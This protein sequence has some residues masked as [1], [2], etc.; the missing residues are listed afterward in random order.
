MSIASLR[1]EIRDANL[2]YLD[3]RPIDE[4]HR[5]DGVMDVLSDCEIAL[6]RFNTNRNN[7]NKPSL[8]ECYGFLQILYVQQDAVKELSQ[9]YGLTG[10]GVPNS[11]TPSKRSLRCARV[12]NLRNQLA[13][14]P[15]RNWARTT[16]IIPEGLI[17]NDY[18]EYALYG[19]GAVG[20]SSFQKGEVNF[21]EFIAR[22]E[23]SLSAQLK[24]IKKEIW[25]LENTYRAQEKAIPLEQIMRSSWAYQ[26]GKVYLGSNSFKDNNDRLHAL[27]CVQGVQAEF[28]KLKTELTNR[29]LWSRVH[30]DHFN[31]VDNGLDW[32]TKTLTTNVKSKAK[33]DLYDLVYHG[34][35]YHLDCIIDNLKCF[36]EQM[37]V[38]LR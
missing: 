32:I 9:L 38:K 8:I 2:F 26:W 31:G 18:F 12:R 29:N 6:H 23:H 21:A 37:A 10:T 4:R 35:N 15:A 7:G 25:R 33:C 5:L 17:Q 1:G 22:N 19:V 13:G 14:H 30:R 16:A 28:Q 27:T 36:D 34:T 11:W 24:R 20:L 3:Q